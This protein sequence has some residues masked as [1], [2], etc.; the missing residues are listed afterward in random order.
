MESNW[1]ISKI[2]QVRILPLDTVF[3]TY[4]RQKIMYY[5]KYRNTEDVIE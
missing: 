3:P 5:I 4:I 2:L 1:I